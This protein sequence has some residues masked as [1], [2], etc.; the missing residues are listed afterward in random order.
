MGCSS[1]PRCAEVPGSGTRRLGLRWTPWNA[2]QPPPRQGRFRART[3]WL[4][5]VRVR[6][7]CDDPSKRSGRLAR[8]CRAGDVRRVRCAPQRHHLL[9]QPRLL[10]RLHHVCRCACP[11]RLPPR[12][13]ARVAGRTSART[14]QA[15]LVRESGSA[16][17][18]S[19]PP[20]RA[21]GIAPLS[22]PSYMRAMYQFWSMAAGES[23]V[24]SQPQQACHAPTLSA[25]P[26]PPAPSL[27]RVTRCPRHAPCAPRRRPQHL[28]AVHRHQPRV[29]DGA[30]A[31]EPAGPRQVDC[32]AL[33]PRHAPR[34][35]A[36]HLPAAAGTRQR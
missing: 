34:A 1:A 7:T 5:S 35:C 24:P 4:T 17:S 31:P 11:L 33:Q 29:A 28:D 19:S 14:L 15:P 8:V 30:H 25:L 36:R 27:P 6:P 13:R 18:S 2:F 12:M 23:R 3:A 26:P 22:Q 32:G 21:G 10:R 20:P 16:V 9:L